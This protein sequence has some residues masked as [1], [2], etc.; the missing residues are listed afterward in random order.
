[1]EQDIKPKWSHHPSYGNVIHGFKGSGIAVPFRSGP[2]PR[3]FSICSV[4]LLRICWAGEVGLGRLRRS[5]QTIP[6]VIDHTSVCG[7]DIQDKELE[8]FPLHFTFP[9]FPRL[10]V[11]LSA[12]QTPALNPKIGKIGPERPP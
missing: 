2:A 12:Y 9:V 8:S 4:P 7:K 11:S 1:M 3:L 5:L 6:S 10:D